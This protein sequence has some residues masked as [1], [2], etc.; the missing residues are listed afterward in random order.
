MRL[1]LLY[2]LYVGQYKRDGKASPNITIS[3]VLFEQMD[4]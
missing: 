2:Q 1:P 3:S 4:K